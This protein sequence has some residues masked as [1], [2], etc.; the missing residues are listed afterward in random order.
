MEMLEKRE[1]LESMIDFV[2][3]DL[4]NV[5]EHRR[6]GLYYKA[7]AIL[8]TD[9][10]ADLPMPHRQDGISKELWG[11]LIN[12]Q[13]TLKNFL[14]EILD[15]KMNGGEIVFEVVLKPSLMIMD[16]FYLRHMKWFEKDLNKSIDQIIL[17]QEI[18]DPD[19]YFLK[20]FVS[21]ALNGIPKSW[22]KKCPECGKFFLH[23]HKRQKIFCSNPC[24]SKFLQRKRRLE[25]RKDPR[26][27]NLWLQ[28][29]RMY[30]RKR[31]ETAVRAN[32]GANVKIKQLKRL[33]EKRLN[34]A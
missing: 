23:P 3:E 10:I 1:V 32:L 7:I 29:M 2:N 5:P 27:Y 33:N 19:S 30:Q 14:N 18:V 31:Y 12:I 21:Q 6:V 22:L 4:S 26:K 15:P 8:P 24:A 16:K 9:E 17:W 20:F 28:K 13:S 25:L 11:D 34:D